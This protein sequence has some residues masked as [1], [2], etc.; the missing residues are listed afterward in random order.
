MKTTKGIIVVL[1][2]LFTQNLLAADDKNEWRRLI[3]LRGQWAFSIGDNPQWKND[4][5]DDRNWEPIFAPSAWEDEG[6]PGYDGY[7]W[8]RKGFNIAHINEN[9]YVHLG[10]IDDVDRVYLNGQLIGASGSNPPNF[11]TAYQTERIYHLPASLLKLNQKNILAIRVYD[12]QLAGGLLDGR[13]GI[14]LKQNN[15]SFLKSFAGYWKFIPGDSENYK[16][17]YYDDSSWPKII[18]PIN[19]ENAGYPDYD[20]YAWYRLYFDF[21]GTDADEDLVFLL[22]KID[23]LDETYLNGQLI[24]ATGHMYRNTENISVDN[25]WSMLRAYPIK[26]SELLLGRN[27]IAIRVYDAKL[28]GGIYEGPIGLMNL[29]DYRNSRWGKRNNIKDNFFWDWL[30]GS[31]F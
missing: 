7:A 17:P 6:Y 9:L 3:D 25:E 29:K 19:W 18:V 28:G 21:D 14:Y 11:I 23:D 20:G 10:R 26:K 5:F 16:D 31:F 13:L 4:D 8:Y 15:P 1:L 27:L 30:H 12:Y 22:G 24:G 2:F